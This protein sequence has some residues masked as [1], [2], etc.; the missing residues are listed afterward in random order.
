MKPGPTALPVG[1]GEGGLDI[2][3]HLSFLTSFSLSLG[4]GP[5]LTA[6]LVKGPL[7]QNNQPTDHKIITEWYHLLAYLTYP[8]N[9]SQ[10]DDNK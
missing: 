10:K 5:T 8:F 2:F 6:I 7:N 3:S 1:V 9:I 4:G